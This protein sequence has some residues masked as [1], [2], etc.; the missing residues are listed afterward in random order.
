[1]VQNPL[2]ERWQ[3][4]E[5]AYTGWLTLPSAWS[6]EVMA[7]AGFDALVIDVQHG[8]AD[9]AQQLA[10]LQALSAAGVP[11]LVRTA[12]NEPSGLMR[13]LDLGAF[14]VICPMIGSGEECEA[15]VAACRYP[16]RG[17]RSFGPTR[18]LL[19]IGSDY[20]AR[21]ESFAL[22]FAQIETAQGLA[23]VEAIAAVP[24]LT[25]LYVGPWDLSLD[26]GLAEPGRLA[27]PQLSRALDAILEACRRHGL[28]P[29][30]YVGSP[31]EGRAMAARGFRLI[32][33]A[34]DTALLHQGAL[35]AVRQARA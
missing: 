32:N 21:A 18:A 16:P 33:I 22:T 12:W 2:L 29:G 31:E 8:L 27:D 23:N 5:P 1:M 4:N 30:I 14:G 15:F 9:G 13:A 17:I 7:H 6:A 11:A 25:G 28:V 26:L 34:T 35:Q 24:G 3:R 20:L 19:A 10:M